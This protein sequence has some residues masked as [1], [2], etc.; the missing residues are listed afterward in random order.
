MQISELLSTYFHMVIDRY[1]LKWYCRF[2][3]SHKKTRQQQRQ[4]R[5][6]VSITQAQRLLSCHGVINNHFRHQRH[7]L[8]A[9]NYCL[10][11]D[12]AFN[13]WAQITCTQN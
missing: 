3:P 11:R 6:F 1:I 12:I 9:R 5:Q 8:K 2:Y 13:Q 4:I 7:L 10:L